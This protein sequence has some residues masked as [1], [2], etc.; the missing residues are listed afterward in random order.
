MKCPSCGADIS[1][2]AASC[3]YCNSSVPTSEAG[4]RNTTFARLKASDAYAASGSPERIARLPKVGAMQKA[5]LYFFFAIFIGGAAL[6]CV[7]GLVIAGMGAIGSFSLGGR[8]AVFSIIPLLFT[9]F[10]IGF[11]VLGVFLFRLAKGKMDKF[12]SDPARAIPVIV[13]DK[14][15]DVWG[16]TGDSSANTSYYVTCETEDSSREEY[17]VWNGSLYGK[18]TAG[19]AG[20]LFVRSKYGLDFDRVRV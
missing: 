20:I 13:V 7:V 9:I 4:N 10:P 3:M 16:G 6:V 12:E 17:Q 15:T 11:I 5:F 18:M 8:G 2:D 1:A 19:D 14:R